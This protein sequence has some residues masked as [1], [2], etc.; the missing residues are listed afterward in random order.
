[1]EKLEV[2]KKGKKILKALGSVLK[3]NKQKKPANLKATPDGVF[4][5]SNKLD[6]SIG[7]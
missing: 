3:R 6:R 2:F 5:H 1:M 7:G 4:T